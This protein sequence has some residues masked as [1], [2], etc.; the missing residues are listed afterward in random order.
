MQATPIYATGD[1]VIYCNRSLRLDKIRWFGFDLDFTLAIYKR[2]EYDRLTYNL[3]T[4]D[5]V[6]L[7][8]YPKEIGSFVFDQ[9][10]IVI[11]LLVDKKRGNTL[12]IDRSANVL[13]CY[14]GRTKIDK[15][16]ISTIYP[17]MR[18][19][20]SQIGPSSYRK[21]THS[22]KTIFTPAH[23]VHSRP[24]SPFYDWSPPF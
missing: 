6:H 18:V 7:M 20:L 12:Q 13:V 19:D 5:L 9:S 4:R 17:S 24:P 15:K 1:D 11:G 16:D 10:F 2:P 3:L 22:T 8:S 21:T 23:V 14:H